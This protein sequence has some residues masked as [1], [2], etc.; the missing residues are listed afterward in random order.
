[1]N[2]SRR[3]VAILRAMLM[4]LVLAYAFALY[5]EWRPLG[6]SVEAM[7]YRQVVWQSASGFSIGYAI[8][9]IG[10][11]IG[12][13]LGLLGAILLFIPMRH[14]LS[15]LIFSAPVLVGAMLAGATPSAYPD[16]EAA[17]TMLL[18]CI[19]SALWGSVVV[20][21][22]LQRRQLFQRAEIAN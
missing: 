7:D 2:A 8:Q 17:T 4:A 13:G 1:M 11:V 5:F 21:V 19:A 12:T 16:V 15:L 20:H 22:A 14:G 10:L 3:P 6:L 9:R 18:W